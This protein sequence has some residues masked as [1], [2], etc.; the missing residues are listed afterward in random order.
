LGHIP[1]QLLEEF[2]DPRVEDAF[3]TLVVDL[4]TD[5]L[6]VRG[7]YPGRVRPT[8]TTERDQEWPDDSKV[9]HLHVLP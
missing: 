1:D 2:F 3:V 9:S 6:D 5:A 7:R 4:P 8:S